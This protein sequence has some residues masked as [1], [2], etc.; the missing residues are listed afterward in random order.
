MQKKLIALAVAG[1]ATAPAFAQSSVTIYGLLDVGYN[2]ISGDGVDSQSNIDGGQM[3]GSR[4]G[5]RGNEDLGGGLKAIWTLE[6]MLANDANAAVG[7]TYPWSST[8]TR[9]SFVGL[10]SDKWGTI[11]AGRLQTNGYD[12][13]C[14]YGGP[15]VGGAFSSVDKLAAVN[16]LGCGSAGRKEDSFQ[17]DSPM[18]NGFSFAY[19]HSR[20]NEEPATAATTGSVGPPVVAGTAATTQES[21]NLLSATYASGPFSVG[22]AYNWVDSEA[23]TGTTDIEEWGIGASYDF[24]FVKVYGMY[25][26]LDKDP[27]GAAKSTDDDKWSISVGIPVF[28]NGLVALTYAD[29]SIDDAGTNKDL[30]AYSWAIG[31]IHNLSKRT[32]LY[33]AYN[34]VSNDSDA[35][36]P[37]RG[38]K[39]KLGGDIEVWG[40]G[41][42]HSF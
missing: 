15:L 24:K 29:S 6:Y 27:P 42:R 3:S 2:H 9:N 32:N 41:I 34:A 19:N 25:Q 40:F 14:A 38:I 12:W 17:Y 23:T 36:Q 7:S 16:S 10:A 33:V 1:L 18:W 5:F 22:L 20:P 21:L 37:I 31:Y 39:P 11:R 4:L 28:G 26:N 35:Q 30:D 13:A 8:A